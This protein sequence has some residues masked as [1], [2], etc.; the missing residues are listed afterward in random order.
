M[1][2]KIL[3]P[4]LL[5]NFVF[6]ACISTSVP[7]P[8]TGQAEPE[9][10]STFTAATAEIQPAGSQFSGQGPSTVPIQKDPGMAILHLKV[11][12][13]SSLILS[14]KGQNIPYW[15]TK[16]ME[17]DQ[18]DDQYQYFNQF[19]GLPDRE[20]K[21]ILDYPTPYEDYDLPPHT[22]MIRI[23][24]VSAE[25]QWEMSILPMSAARSI[26]PGQ[27]IN[28]SHSDVLAVNGNLS[29]LQLLFMNPEHEMM[30][31]D[32]GGFRVITEDGTSTNLEP[33]EDTEIYENIPS[34]VV[35]LVVYSGGYWE[36]Q[37]K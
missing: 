36:I 15:P 35:Y 17:T 34:G 13:C 30:L 12:N 9:L 29:G 5:V 32:F 23:E 37:T 21:I 31:Q 14:A 22:E 2:T 28:G 19:Q 26:S 20:Q 24:D 16:L 6:I 1:K 10:N 11:E 18:F 8:D 7:L 3:I 27:T 4:I 25:C 33:V